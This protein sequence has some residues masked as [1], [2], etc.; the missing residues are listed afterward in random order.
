M[1]KPKK[2]KPSETR[3]EQLLALMRRDN[4]A[5]LTDITGATNWLPHSARAALSGL[6]RKGVSIE[7]RKMDGITR[8]FVTLEPVA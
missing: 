8:Y 7:K 5:S 1:K 3:S 6:R 4:G 2:F